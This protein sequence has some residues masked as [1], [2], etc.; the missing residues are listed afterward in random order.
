MDLGAADLS[1]PWPN[2]A[3][4]AP[5]GRVQLRPRLL[6]PLGATPGIGRGYGAD[7]AADVRRAL[8]E[9]RD[10]GFEVIV[11]AGPVPARPADPIAEAA[12]STWLV[13]DD[14]RD[15]A[16]HRSGLVTILVAPGGVGPGP[17]EVRRC[18]RRVRNLR[19]A[20]LEILAGEAMPS[21][22]AS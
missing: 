22:G 13:T 4:A 17:G 15:C 19:G 5:A 14:P 9:L 20:V 6:V 1:G 8:A 16:A 2:D 11:T 12:P 7:A 10:A 3:P 18:D 21:P